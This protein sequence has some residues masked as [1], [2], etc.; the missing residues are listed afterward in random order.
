[1]TLAALPAELIV[2]NAD[3]RTMDATRPQAQAIAIAG[4]RIT[5]L[6]STA[7]MRAL[8]GPLT[9]VIDAGGR[10]VL[11]G[12]QDAHVHL[13]DGGISL[14]ND[15]PLW[16][17]TTEAG[18]IGAMSRHAM[19][20]DAALVVG[21]GWQA[22]IFGDH[23][24]TRDVLDRAVTDRPCIVLDSSFH[25]ACLNSAA[26][27]L[28]GLS[29]GM[30]D[31]PNGHVVRDAAGRPTGMLHEDAVPWAEARLPGV[32]DA[33]R[34]AGLRAGQA[35]ANR[36]G[37]TGIIDPKV[38]DYHARI[39]GRVAA[40]GA[41]D[42]RVAGAA[43]VTPS[44]DAAGAVA[45]LNGLRAAHP[46][47]DFHINAAK[48]FFDGVLENRTAAMLS[49]Y[50]DGAGGNAPV[51]FAPIQIAEIF[52][53]LDAARFQIHVHV[54]GD[55]AARAALDGLEAAQKTNGTWPALHQ[56]AHLQVTDAADLP[57]LQALGAMANIQ[58]LWARLDPVVPDDW[59][60]L[61]GVGRAPMVY[62]FRQMLDHGAA[63]CL[64][65][66]WPVTTLNPFEIIGTAVTR[67]PPGGVTP[68]FFPAEGLT[69]AEAIHGY[70]V[71]AAQ[72]CWRA[73]HTGRLKPGFSADLIVLDRDVTTCP[74]Q[75][76][77]ETQVL[78]TL[79]KGRVVHRDHDFRG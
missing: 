24:L 53:A 77:S 17:V 51:M 62:A 74:A 12:F 61:V 58:P 22:G 73:G 50:A 31:P 79:F 37:I 78:L 7:A 27:G 39:Y 4:G 29:P 68:A 26:C 49:P 59:L 32:S 25:N 30:A 57:R 18:L 75:A 3:I 38:V 36:H 15:A 48:F 42:L 45:R 20:S 13:L 52:T 23:N 19:G 2:L 67:R 63:I 41:L 35:H 44:D 43:S 65:S 1:V 33:I 71:G 46:G 28:L 16:D 9:H 69:V 40:A 55:A 10:L 70:T 54:I 6:G 11:P 60:A 8:A 76:I 34:M 47:P 56:L 72:A 5:A 66:D 64:S 14:V 21:A